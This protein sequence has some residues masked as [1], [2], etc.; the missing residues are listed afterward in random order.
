MSPSLRG[1]SEV[2]GDNMHIR[3]KRLLGLGA[4]LTLGAVVVVFTTFASAASGSAQHVRWDIVSVSPIPIAPPPPV[5]FNPGGVAT[6]QTPE[7][8]TITLTGSGTFAA[9]ASGGGS[10]AVTGGG[11]WSISG[12]GGSGT[13]KV[14]ELVAWE[15]GSPQ[16]LLIGGFPVTDNTGDTT[17]RTNGTAVLRIEFSDGNSGVLTVGCHGPGAPAG[18]FEGIATTKG[19]TTYYN[20]PAPPANGNTG[21]TL[22]HVRS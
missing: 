21:R 4:A 5:T 16:L 20:V 7:G 17:E 1:I 14:T 19:Y 10:N 15:F 3:T 18:I 22:F 8:V 2:K 6:A 13:Y 11:T 9:P 12:G